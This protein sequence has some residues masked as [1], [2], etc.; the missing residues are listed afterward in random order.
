[1]RHV[2]RVENEPIRPV[3]YGFALYFLVAG[4]DSFRIGNFGSIL[5]IVA[6]IP[7]MFAFFDLMRLRVRFSTPL[8]FQI[9]YWLLAV[10]SIFYTFNTGIT[11]TWAIRLTLNLALVVLLGMGEQ[12]NQREL[13]FLK[14][15]LSAGGWCT[16]IMMLIFSDISVGGRLTLLLGDYKQ[17]QN[18]INGYFMYT[19][20]YHSNQLFQNRKKVHIIPVVFIFLIVLLTG[21]R[22]ALLAYIL[23][24]FAHVCI[25]FTHTKH[26]FRNISLVLLLTVALYFSFVLILPQIGNSVTERFSWEYISEGGTSGRTSIW[27][28]LFQH[29]SQDNIPRLMFGHGYGSTSVIN[30]LTF[31]VAHNV[32]LDDLV[33]LG[34]IGLIFQIVIQV[35]IIRIL[36]KYRQY[37]LLC[38]YF[39]MIGMS[40]SLSLVAYKPIWNIMILALAIDFYE[41][42]KDSSSLLS[43]GVSQEVTI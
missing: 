23:V 33:G 26:K 40:M 4:M 14:K 32:Y 10:I 7:M 39:G 37:S 11:Q 34:I 12:Y 8:L 1:M 6:F 36:S 21:S 20:S 3:V 16:I 15:S 18:Y 41:K 13:Q 28:F 9:F 22:G 25:S 43:N 30:T 27:L 17:D 24:I 42:T 2:S 19:F 35:S 38:A 31:A 5:K 29:L